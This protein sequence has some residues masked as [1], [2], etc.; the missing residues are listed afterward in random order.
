MVDRSQIGLQKLLSKPISAESMAS[1]LQTPD[2]SRDG[3][4]PFLLACL[5]G[6]LSTCKYLEKLGADIHSKSWR[7]GNV[8]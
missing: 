5:S 1:L 8:A 7:C 2:V 3:A 4:T 6:N